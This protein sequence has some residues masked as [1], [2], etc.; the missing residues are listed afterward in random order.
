VAGFWGLVDNLFF[1]PMQGI[2]LFKHVSLLKARKKIIV[3]NQMARNN[4]IAA[5]Y[6]WRHNAASRRV[7]C[8]AKLIFCK[9]I[10]LLFA[11]SES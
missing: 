5:R 8:D 11:L 2:T 4:I 9:Q 10:P 7:I 6:T 1:R 3:Q